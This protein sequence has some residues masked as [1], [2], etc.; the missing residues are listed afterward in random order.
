MAAAH[1][2]GLVALYIAANGRAHTYQDVMN[3]RQAIVNNSQAQ[4][5]WSTSGNS[6]DWDGHPEPLATPSENWV[7]QPN[8][9]VA[10][11][12]NLPTELNFNIVPGYTY[13]VQ[14]RN[15]LALANPWGDFATTNGMGS[16]KT[17]VLSNST[18]ES[19]RFYQL[20]RQRSP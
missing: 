13:T 11:T 19:M 14:Y 3:I 8:I 5:N 18:T 15:A 17:V 9:S 10:K 12:I 7:P 20:K 4:T 2:S 6:G 16:L 1:V